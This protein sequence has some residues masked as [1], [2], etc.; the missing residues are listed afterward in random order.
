MSSLLRRIATLLTILLL[1]TAVGLVS[2][3]F[4]ERASYRK[5]R[6]DAHNALGIYAANL[7]GELEKYETLP[8]V[9]ANFPLFGYML[10]N[11]ERPDLIEESN[12]KLT[13]FNT[14][15]G[16]LNTYLINAEGIII[17]S[18]NWEQPDSFI[19]E[20][21]NFRPYFTEARDNGTAGY[22]ALG[23][24]SGKRGYYFSSAV[25]NDGEFLGVMVVKVDMANLEA[26]W[27]QGTEKVI[28]TDEDGM[29]FISAI[30]G[31]LYRTLTQ[32]DDETTDRILES[33]RYASISPS[34]LPIQTRKQIDP[35][36][37]EL[38]ML[39]EHSGDT[40][41][42]LQHSVPMAKWGWVLHSL[43]DL[44]PV[45]VNVQRVI[46]TST[47]LTLLLCAGYVIWLTRRQA[48][49]D[50]IRV[51]HEMNTRLKAIN[52]QLESEVRARTHALTATNQQLRDEVRERQLAQTELQAA[53]EQLVQTAKMAAI[54]QMASSIN[55]ELNQPLSAIRTFADNA[56]QF[57]QQQRYEAVDQNLGLIA[58]MSDR[59]GAI[60]QHLKSFS[61][62]A[63]DE[64]EAVAV[65]LVI[66]D[67]LAV[68]DPAI[69]RL[70]VRLNFARPE[71]TCVA[72]AEPIRLQQVLT[73]LLQN[74]LDSVSDQT[75]GEVTVSLRCDDDTVIVSVEDNGSGM[76][77]Q[78]LAQIYEPFFTTKPA[79]RG[80]GLGL[81]ISFAIVSDFGGRL[82]ASN[83]DAGGARFEVH[84][85]RTKPLP[86]GGTA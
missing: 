60:M 42:Y 77:E 40:L 41:R 68:M 22:F 70:S 26:A 1:T 19:G 63:S 82:L 48:R 56:G 4:T 35:H 54:G 57:L 3:F 86:Q 25:N 18:S 14:L 33:R 17:A 84:L 31:W 13:H 76:D 59:M 75:G 79:G 39:D 78:T 51:E 66:D 30:D 45:R 38:A 2:A 32:L 74:A 46:L 72:L 53:Q 6:Q 29:V 36:V 64:L 52:D 34:P 9:L 73:N 15:A 62:K 21:L 85:R 8:Q 20:D 50:R 12:R 49:L 67:T 37:H 5:L 7:A 81:S 69:R 61:R 27:R 16:A 55:H 80:L 10:E 43:S 71:Q 23:T 28:V 83:L 44:A 65:N 24:T 58:N 11:A 47:S